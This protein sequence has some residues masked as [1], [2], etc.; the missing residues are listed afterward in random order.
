MTSY[1]PDPPLPTFF[2]IR[3]RSQNRVDPLI[4]HQAANAKARY[5]LNTLGSPGGAEP[6][7]RADTVDLDI[8]AIRRRLESVQ[9]SSEGAS[10]CQV[11][12]NV[13]NALILQTNEASTYGHKRLRVEGCKV[14]TEASSC[15]AKWGIQCHQSISIAVRMAQGQC[16]DGRV[17]VHE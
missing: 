2:N 12:F 13:S 3:T 10:F 9:V 11:G 8:E 7:R 5:C 14:S 1:A 4:V 6:S 15:P 16:R 17:R